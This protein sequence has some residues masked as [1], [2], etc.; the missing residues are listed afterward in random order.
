MFSFLLLSS[1][2]MLQV[3]LS[4]WEKLNIIYTLV[5][6][7]KKAQKTRPGFMTVSWNPP[8]AE[9]ADAKRTPSYSLDL[10]FLSI[11]MQLSDMMTFLVRSSKIRDLQHW[12]YTIC[13]KINS[14]NIGPRI[15]V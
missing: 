2:N 13:S 4:Q 12:G 14:T 3:L 1:Q 9:M 6:N 8:R 5:F 7:K 10:H 15:E 11:K